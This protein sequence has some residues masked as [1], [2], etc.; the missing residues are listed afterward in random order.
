[1]ETFEQ[2]YD[3]L[4]KEGISP[5]I[6]AGRAVAADLKR[7][8]S[9][10]REKIGNVQHCVDILMSDYNRRDRAKGGG[11]G[12]FDWDW[13]KMPIGSDPAKADEI[14][15]YGSFL[16][17]YHADE[18]KTI[19]AVGNGRIS[20]PRSFWHVLENQEYKGLAE[21]KASITSST[22][23]VTDPGVIQS[24]R[25]SDFT[26]LAR[27]RLTLRDILPSVGTSDGVVDYV[28]ES[29]F[30]GGASP[31]AEGGSK[32][33]STLSFTAQKTIPKTIAH[34]TSA[35]RQVLADWTQLTQVINDTMLYRLAL[36][37]ENQL[38]VGD[39]LLEHISGLVPNAAAY[40]GTFNATGDTRLDTLRNAICE[41]ATADETPDFCVLNP[42]DT[43]RIDLIKDQASNVGNY[44]VGAPMQRARVS[45]KTYWGLLVIESNTMPQSTFLVGDSSKCRIVD[46]MSG[47]VE[48]SQSHADYFRLNMVAIRAEERVGLA[49]LRT[50][51]FLYGTFV[52]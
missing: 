12:G 8:D 18:L 35:S 6:A 9:M 20:S 28:R 38:L 17:K 23:G 27:R 26:S 37:E 51:S 2:A 52:G 3:R 11:V 30:S 29:A 21:F 49:I 7:L 44:V 14:T 5:E 48:F 32:P 25:I 34:F 40:A 31:V 41:L 47:T 4:M 19:A 16:P 39:G 15:L 1:M 50:T 36:E 13:K 33:E 22:V 46:R 43:R 24:D 42:A 45:A 10:Y